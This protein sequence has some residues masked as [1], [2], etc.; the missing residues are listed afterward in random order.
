MDDDIIYVALNSRHRI[1]I[2]SE[3]GDTHYP[4]KLQEWMRKIKKSG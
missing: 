2:F 1:R 4:R 3:K